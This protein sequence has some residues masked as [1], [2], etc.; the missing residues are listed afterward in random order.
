MPKFRNR[1]AL[2]F[3]L[4]QI[5]KQLAKCVLLTGQKREYI[6]EMCFMRHTDGYLLHELKK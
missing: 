6:A 2:C 5:N 1:G 3:K 4:T